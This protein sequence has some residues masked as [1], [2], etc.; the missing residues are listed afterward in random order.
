MANSELCKTCS[1]QET[2]HELEPGKT[3]D[4][5]ISEFSHFEDCPVIGCGGDCK[6]FI[7]SEARARERATRRLSQVWFLSGSDLVLMDIGT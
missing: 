7:A 5:F 1:F 2:V 4:E 6:E 3:C